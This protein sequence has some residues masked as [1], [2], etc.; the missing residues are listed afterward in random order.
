[1]RL[2]LPTFN[3]ATPHGG[4]FPLVCDSRAEA[5]RRGGEP[6]PILFGNRV[7]YLAVRRDRAIDIDGEEHPLAELLLAPLTLEA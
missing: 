1:M 2:T 5:R 6:Y 4:D 3:G 7:K